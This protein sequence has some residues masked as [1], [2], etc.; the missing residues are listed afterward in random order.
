[1][2]VKI[3]PF[4]APLSLPNPAPPSPRV[5]VIAASV[6]ALA[7]SHHG[8]LTRVAL[9]ASP[10]S[11]PHIHHISVLLMHLCINLCDSLLMHFCVFVVV[12]LLLRLR[13]VVLVLVLG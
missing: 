4:L 2:H 10:A 7:L 8:V 1:M 12:D 5:T 13:A 9:A 6:I 11:A 3:Y